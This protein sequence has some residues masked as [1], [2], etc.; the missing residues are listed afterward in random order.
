LKQLALEKNGKE[1]GPR[2]LLEIIRIARRE[3][4]K[5]IFIIEQYRPPFIENLAAE[6]EAEI[7]SLNPLAEDYMT[8]MERVADQLARALRAK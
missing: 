6:L 3:T 8:N 7:V 1:T 4:I 2:S 5:T